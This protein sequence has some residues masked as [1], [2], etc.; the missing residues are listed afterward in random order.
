[1]CGIV[2]I[3]GPLSVEKLKSAVNRMNAALAHRGPDEEGTWA[4]EGFA[5]GMRRLSIIDLATGRQPMWDKETAKGLVYNGEVY[6]YR[7]LRREMEQRGIHFN[8]TSDTEVVL[9][10]LSLHGTRAVHDWN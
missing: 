9:K 5:F 10:S 8:T 2:G 7:V 1:M 6:N 4:E 3:G